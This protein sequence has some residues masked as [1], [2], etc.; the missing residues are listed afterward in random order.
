MYDKWM[1][2]REEQQ[3]AEFYLLFVKRFHCAA[4]SITRNNKR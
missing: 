2:I 1:K 4:L 3:L